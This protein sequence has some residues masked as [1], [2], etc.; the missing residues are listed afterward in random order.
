MGRQLSG[1]CLL[2]TGVMTVVGAPRGKHGLPG[3]SY[4]LSDAV[5]SDFP[6]IPNKD[7]MLNVANGPC[8]WNANVA[9]RATSWQSCLGG[10]QSPEDCFLKIPWQNL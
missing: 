6:L 1:A 8:I 9:C 10:K 2:V 7:T 4:H 3:G 5:R